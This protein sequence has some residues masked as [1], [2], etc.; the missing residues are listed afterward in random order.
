[1]PNKS[2]KYGLKIFWCCDSDTACQL[3]AEVYLERQ[4][5]TVAAAKDANLTRNP[6]ERLVHP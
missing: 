3:N 2:G 4:V 1:M 6:V 5:R